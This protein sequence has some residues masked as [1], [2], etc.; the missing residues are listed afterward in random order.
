MMLKSGI[1]LAGLAALSVMAVAEE[2]C[3]PPE[4]MAALVGEQAFTQTRTLSGVDRPIISNGTVVVSE[5]SVV[6]TVT[7]PVE[8][9]TRVT[10]DGIFQSVMGGPETPLN[11]SGAG[12]PILTE[13]GLLAIMRG[14]LSASESYYTRTMYELAEDGWTT[15]LAP[16]SETV[17]PHLTSLTLKGC[18]EL[19]EITIHQPNGDAVNVVFGVE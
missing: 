8:I 9:S 5:N 4:T 19:E 11:S 14:D 7:A 18:T 1:V 16:K 17:S 3:P 2:T 10:E 13:T 15:E 6:W 12:N